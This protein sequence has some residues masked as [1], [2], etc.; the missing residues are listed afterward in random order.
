MLI[1]LLK[2]APPALFLAAAHIVLAHPPQDIL[3]TAPVR[4]KA[5]ADSEGCNTNCQSSAHRAILQVIHAKTTIG[6]MMPMYW[7]K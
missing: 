3:L 7:M 5:R 1:F 4:C 6:V 2:L